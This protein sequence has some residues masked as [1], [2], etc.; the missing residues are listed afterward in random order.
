MPTLSSVQ[1]VRPGTLREGGEPVGKGRVLDAF[2]ELADLTAFVIIWGGDLSYAN[3]FEQRDLKDQDLGGVRF[4]EAELAGCDL[5]G[6]YL[7]GEDLARANL[8]GARLK[9]ADLR[10]RTWRAWTSRPW[11]FAA[12]SLTSRGPCCRLAASAPRWT[13]SPYAA[14]NHRRGAPYISVR[15]EPKEAQ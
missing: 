7:G 1:G 12:R 14:R 3:L 5:T 10:G 4:V 15:G 11:T 8:S 2:L 13:V 9:G 6:T